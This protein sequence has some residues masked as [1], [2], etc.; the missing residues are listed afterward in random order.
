MT[1]QL[2]CDEGTFKTRLGLSQY[3]DPA[4]QRRIFPGFWLALSV[5]RRP[6][7][8]GRARAARRDDAG[9]P[10]A[11]SRFAPPSAKFRAVLGISVRIAGM[12]V[13]EE[14]STAHCLLAKAL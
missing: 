2:P 10:A 7:G 1:H 11:L 5:H 3:R 6:G 4:G 8:C 13:R 9:A 14:R 12:A